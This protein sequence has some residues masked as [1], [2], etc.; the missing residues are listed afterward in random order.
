MPISVALGIIIKDNKILL[1]KR[2]KKGDFKDYIALPGGKVEKNEHISEAAK[3]ELFEE[4]RIKTKFKKYL[5][6][7]SELLVEDNN[8]KSHFIL[9]I[10]ELEPI[11]DEIISSDE[12]KMDWYDLDLIQKLE[13]EIIPS[14]YQMIKNFVFKKE[15]NYFDCIEEKIG[16]EYYIKKFN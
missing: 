7:V 11:T 6:C 5:G 12:G 2:K 13:Q 9:H 8:V 16:E 3:R 15:Q 14:D 10:C 4:S 1:I